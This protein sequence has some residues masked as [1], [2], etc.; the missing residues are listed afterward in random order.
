MSRSL[1]QGSFLSFSSLIR[2][3][4]FM[5]SRNFLSVDQSHL[6]LGVFMQMPWFAWQS[7]SDASEL[8]LVSQ[9]HASFGRM[10]L[11]Q[12]L[13]HGQSIIWNDIKTSSLLKLEYEQHKQRKKETEIGVGTWNAT[14]IIPLDVSGRIILKW[15][16]QKY[17]VD[18]NEVVQYKVE[19][20]F[21][22][23]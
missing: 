12:C 6:P 1:V 21:L 10:S 2:R 20:G 13:H 7:G 4:L 17:F 3:R 23:Q 19:T 16:L 15:K 5:H 11:E 22:D 8:I 9:R 18:W 14:E